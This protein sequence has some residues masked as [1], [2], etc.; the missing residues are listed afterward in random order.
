MI[1]TEADF[2]R[3]VQSC[4]APIYFFEGNG[5]QLL[6]DTE[7]FTINGTLTLFRKDVNIF[8]ITN[9]HVYKEG[10]LDR[11]NNK[12]DVVCQVG[13]K[14][15]INLEKRIIYENEDKDLIV[16]FLH[17]HELK[18][19]A[20]DAPKRGFKRINTDIEKLLQSQKE[21]DENTWAAHFAGFP[22]GDKTTEKISITRI[23]ETFDIS[24]YVVPMTY[25]SDQKRIL[26]NF[27]LTRAA[28]E[29]GRLKMDMGDLSKGPLVFG[30]ISGSPVFARCA[31]Y[32]DDITLLGIVYGGW[33]EAVFAR[34]ISLI[35]KILQS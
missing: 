34:P 9:Y 8:G 26:L 33:G 10:Y 24:L 20:K 12:E 14:L 17:E 7:R 4:I 6:K 32:E 35:E 25:E 18:D 23:E 19:I 13:H 31:P 29:E 28:I 2:Y 1:K 15:R 27:Y 21:E 30:G 3:R 11:K 22:G 16:F 5:G